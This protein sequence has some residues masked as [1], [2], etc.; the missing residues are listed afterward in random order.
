MP[1]KNPN[2][3]MEDEL[4]QMA[5]PPRSEPSSEGQTIARKRYQFSEGCEM[6]SELAAKL[7]I[8]QKLPIKRELRMLDLVSK[9]ND[10]P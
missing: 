4:E 6:A 3:E 10:F 9:F 7:A 8:V 2:A 5:S 1:K